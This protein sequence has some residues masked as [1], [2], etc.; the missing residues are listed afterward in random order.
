MSGDLPHNQCEIGPRRFLV[1]NRDTNQTKV[2]WGVVHDLLLDTRAIPIVISVEW[3]W[4]TTVVTPCCDKRL[5]HDPWM[6]STHLFCRTLCPR[7]RDTLLVPLYRQRKAGHAPQHKTPSQRH[8]WRESC[9]TIES[10]T[11]E[12][13]PSFRCANNNNNQY[14]YIYIYIWGVIIIN[15]IDRYILV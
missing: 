7:R 10:N 3:P 11:N 13:V 4:K 1:S 15:H 14:I 9:D 12:T 6:W 2:R 8:F 5:Y